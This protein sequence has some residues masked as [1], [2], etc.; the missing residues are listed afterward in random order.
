MDRTPNMRNPNVQKITEENEEG[1]DIKPL[2]SVSKIINL[3]EPL[4]EL[5]WVLND[6]FL[7]AVTQSNCVIVLD[8]LLYAF[9]LAS[10][11]SQDLSLEKALKINLG[12]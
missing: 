2:S 6:A 1:D 5:K 8:S 3:G 7:L 12:K 4:N 9:N 11:S 10:I